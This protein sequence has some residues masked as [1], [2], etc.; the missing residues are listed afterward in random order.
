MQTISNS[1]KKILVVD[2]SRFIRAVLKDEIH[3][4]LKIDFEL[5]MAK[6]YQEAKELVEKYNFHVAILDVN[7]PDAPNGEVID[8]LLEENVPVIV[9]TG[10]MSESTK[11]IILSKDI[12]EY[13]TKNSPHNFSYIISLVKLILN[14]YN[15][16]ILVVDDSKTSRMMTRLNL[17]NLHFNVLE[18]INGE[19]AID[20][21]ENT[22]EKISLVLTDYEMDRMNG[23]ELTMELRQKYMRDILAIIAVS[24]SD[25]PNVATDFL[26]HGAND[27]IKKPYTNKEL[28]ARININLEL[29]DLFKDV[30]EQ[31]NRDFLTGLHNRR[32]FFENGKDIFDR[33]K[34]KNSKLATIMIDIDFFKRINDTYGHGVGDIAIKEIVVILNRFF[35]KNELI[36][37][38]GGEEFCILLEYMLYGELQKKFE[39]VRKAF[40]EN[41]I[42]VDNQEISYTVSIGIFYG[43][44]NSLEDMI[45]LCDEALY[46]AKESGRNRVVINRQ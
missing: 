38:F 22:Q 3:K 6:S 29:L 37:R 45:N 7:L 36:A 35:S 25:N 46:E 8:L 4:S 19:D 26:R 9:L 1:F 23:M 13:V 41:I 24:G 34:Q 42:K 14:N 16:Y 40:E 2:D 31:A 18:A 39:K 10:G 28:N 15:V 32:F 44:S 21:I 33:A 12:V 43:L 11:S 20:I 5:I 17:E 27:F 30:K